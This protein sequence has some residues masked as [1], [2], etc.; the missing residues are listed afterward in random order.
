VQFHGSIETPAAGVWHIPARQPLLLVTGRRPWSRSAH[1]PLTSA[2]HVWI[3]SA[4]DAISFSLEAAGGAVRIEGHVV[5]VTRLGDWAAC[6]VVTVDGVTHPPRAASL[7]YNGVFVRGERAVAWLSLDIA[8]PHGRGAMRLT[9][10]VNAELPLDAAPLSD[11]PH[12]AAA[13][14]LVSCAG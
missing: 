5:E 2:G 9:G 1:S 7:R 4:A 3:G 11:E 14:R 6:V 10:H 8:V 12:A 13:D